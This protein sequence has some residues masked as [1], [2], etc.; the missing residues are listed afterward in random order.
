MTLY[1]NIYI[2]L[3]KNDKKHTNV[4]KTVEGLNPI[5]L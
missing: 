4:H 3:K 1:K 5:L 2:P